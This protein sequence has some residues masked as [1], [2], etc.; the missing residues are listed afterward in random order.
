MPDTGGSNIPALNDL[1]APYGM[2]FGDRV[3]EG[4]YW[5]ADHKGKTLAAWSVDYLT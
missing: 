3:Y 1:L 5:L 2:A 4:D